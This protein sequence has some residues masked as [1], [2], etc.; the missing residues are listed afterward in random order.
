M[1][2]VDILGR[3][4]AP[5]S[6]LTHLAYALLIISMLMRDMSWLRAI[7][8]AA[9]VLRI[10]NRAFVHV[11]YVVVFWESIFVAVNV[12]QLLL[13][14]YYARR[15]R[16]SADEQVFLK[17]LP[18][19]VERV[20]A[21]RLLRLST[22]REVE[23][24]AVLTRQGEPMTDLLFVTEGVVQIEQGDR[25]VAVC[26]AGDFIGEMSFL[27]G[28]NANATARAAHPLRVIAFDQK[29]LRAAL[30]RDANLRRAL[31]ASFSSGLVGKLSKS[32]APGAA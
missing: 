19:G 3:I 25:I 31:D 30:D 10:T 17:H 20:V 2:L 1:N 8:I 21:Q 26:G 11:D 27:S 16:F 4:L 5:D 22:L 13:L 6:V 9:G 28:A 32:Q 14:W 18:K 23:D 29:K 7:A 12:G 15:H 24:G